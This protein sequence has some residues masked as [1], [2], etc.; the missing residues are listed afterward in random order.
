M[1]R[2]L[3]ALL[4]GV[5]GAVSLTSAALADTVALRADPVASAEVVTLGDLFEGAGRAGGVPVAAAPRPGLSTVLD[6]AAVQ[7]A[8]QNAG[9]EWSNAQGMR[10][11]IVR[12]ASAPAAPAAAGVASA[13]SAV[14]PRAGAPAAAEV[15]V[16]ARNINTGEVVQAEDLT[17]GRAVAPGDAVSDADAVI[18]QA[19]R[20]PLRAGAAATLRDTSSPQ[21]IARGDAVEV[22]WRDGGLSLT[23]RGQAQGAAALGQ[24]LRVLNASSRRTIEVVAT[25]PGQAVAGPE[26]Q[27][28]RAQL[29]TNPAAARL[30]LR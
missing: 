28:L 16:W 20:R 29:L 6:A 4:A 15:L 13:A 11:I 17:W 2:F 14:R 24:P 12:S 7:R 19:A 22:T 10:R 23:I 30:A 5:A 26:A 3:R 27:R 9:L 8:A 25:G 21:V 1:T 18:G